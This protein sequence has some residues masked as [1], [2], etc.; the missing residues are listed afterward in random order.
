MVTKMKTIQ[1]TSAFRYMQKQKAACLSMCVVALLAVTA[2][3]GIRFTAYALKSNGNRFWT[4]TAFRDIEIVAPTLL[5]G[6]DLDRIRATDGVQDAEPVWHVSATVS[7]NRNTEIDVVSL[8]ERINMVIL[9]DG[10]MPESAGECLLESP[11]LEE[12]GLSVGDTIR[13]ENTQF[14]AI[15]DYIVC[16]VV[17]HADHACLPLQ[18]PGSR[19]ALV[20]PDAFD[21]EGLEHKCMR[22]VVRISGSEDADRFSDHYLTLS[23][24]VRD[25]LDKLSRE[26]VPKENGTPLESFLTWFSSFL[27]GTRR[28]LTLDVWGSTSYYAIRSASENVA[29]IG[30][31]FAA[32]F[33]IV[34][35][36]VI[37]AS[38]RRMVKEDRTRIGTAKA[39]GFRGNEIAFKYFAAGLIPTLTGMLVGVAIGYSVIQPILLSIYGRFYVYGFGSPVFRL[40]LTAFVLAAGSLIAALAVLIACADLLRQSAVRLMND[41]SSESCVNT[42]KTDPSGRF[43]YFRLILRSLRTGWRPI[44]VIVVGIAGCMALLV[45]GFTIRLSVA[46]TIDRQFTDV[47]RY[48]LK[49][50]FAP[51]AGEGETPTQDKIRSALKGAGLSRQAKTD[52]WIELTDRDCLFFAGGRMNSGE[53]ICV[54]PEVL[55]GYFILADPATGEPFVPSSETGIYIHLRTAETAELAP[56]DR[57]TLYIDQMKTKLITVA[58][59][60]DNYIGG[61]MILSRSAFESVFREEPDCNCFWVRCGK[62]KP[63]D[64]Q[65]ALKGLPVTVTRATEKKAEYKGYTS[66]L[67][68][69]AGLLAG[70]AAL[71]AAGVLANLIYLQ[72]YRKKRTL[73]IMRI[74]GFSVAGTMGYVLWESV[75]T[76]A[77]GLI[78]GISGGSLLA[79]VIIGL[80]E[81]RQLHIVRSVQ[82]LGWLISASVMLLFSIFIH[83]VVVRAVLRLKPTDDVM[84]R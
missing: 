6:E 27:G 63:E 57:L 52:G 43:P 47:E 21:M 64:I 24:Q 48:D 10:R 54:D 65:S 66:A 53:L 5:S 59:V 58:G 37:Y 35:A 71:M 33:V 29:T 50:R 84:I 79:R 13:L 69:I 74:N 26:A 45:T 72:F 75:F 34:G 2:F 67:D 8:T 32:V 7:G 49:I 12:L 30:A 36:F 70:I 60:F 1:W 19:Y 4:Q 38:I 80:M 83:V 9:R 62:T 28:W 22:A 17:D 40:V 73:V 77:V 55:D 41:R 15:H 14:L 81:G 18:V 25:R 39:M 51:D 31:T 61:Q 16:G 44:L 82:P 78:L 23:G 56:G 76:H 68:M 11:V 46:R 42:F 3:L 20:M